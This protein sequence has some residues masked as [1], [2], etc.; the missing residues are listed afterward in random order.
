MHIPTQQTAIQ[1]AKRPLSPRVRKV[2]RHFPQLA[3]NGR[4]GHLQ[5][6]KPALAKTILQQEFF[7]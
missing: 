5:N 2:R 4:N 3:Q 7:K 1:F 6:L